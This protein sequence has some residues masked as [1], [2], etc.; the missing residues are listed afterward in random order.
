M[1]INSNYLYINNIYQ[2]IISAENSDKNINTSLNNFLNNKIEKI[3]YKISPLDEFIN[4]ASLFYN[5]KAQNTNS[6]PAKITNLYKSF[7]YENSIDKILNI[8]DIKIPY[9]ELIK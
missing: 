7:Y 4:K 5:N 2:K 6:P 8:V 3:P 1:K 9:D